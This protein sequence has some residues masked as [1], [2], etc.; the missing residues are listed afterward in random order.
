MSAG[1]VRRE[2]PWRSDW[3][4]LSEVSGDMQI[5]VKPCQHKDTRSVAE[6]LIMSR[7]NICGA[8]KNQMGDWCQPARNTKKPENM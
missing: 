6:G 4:L 3:K 7:C 2:Y 8:G 1:I 5:V